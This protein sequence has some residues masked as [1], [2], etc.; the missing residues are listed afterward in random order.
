VWVEVIVLEGVN[1]AD[2]ERV[3]VKDGETVRVADIDI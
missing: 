3:G 2:L 1:E